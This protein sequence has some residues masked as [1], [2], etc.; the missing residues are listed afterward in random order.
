V[1]KLLSI[2]VVVAL[3]VTVGGSGITSGQGAKPAELVMVEAGGASGQ[4][5]EKG[6]LEPFTR[7]TGIKVKRLSPNDFGKLKAMIASGT[8]TVDLFELGGQD[9]ETAAKTG[10]IEKLDLGGVPVG[11]LY[12][13][14]VHTHGM[15][16]Q[17]YST[18]L[19]WRKGAF[20]TD[21][22]SW[23]DFWDVKKFPGPRCVRDR[24]VDNLEFAL[25]ADGVPPDKIYPIDM[26]RAFRKLS[27]LKPHIAT[28][29]TAG[30]Q[31]P[32]LLISGEVVMVAAWSGRIQNVAADAP[33]AYTWDQAIIHI[34]YF[35]I[36]KGAPNRA[37]AL[38]LFP[39]IADP[40]NEARAAEVIA[41]TGPNRKMFDHIPKDKLHLYP[42]APANYAK[43]IVQRQDWW[44]EHQPEAE[45]RWNEWKL[46]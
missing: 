6:Y 30:A 25:L 40:K 43:Q 24:A 33:V 29:W 41:Y 28:Y 7:D 38:K 14:A 27:E 1:I 32:Q 42:T 11:D 21:P 4:S 45:R 23:K 35:T 34:S 39:Y 5:I 36:P 10:L 12:K 20:P 26:D 44:A 13:E 18:V 8:V 31:P 9:V 46:K 17:Y 22:A 15:G 2:V 3:V 16:Y 37:W 19:A